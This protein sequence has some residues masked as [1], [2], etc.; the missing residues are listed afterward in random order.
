MGQRL[1]VTH[2]PVCTGQLAAN[3]KR[4]RG[5]SRADTALRN[6]GSSLKKT[7][8]GFDKKQLREAPD[9]TERSAPTYRPP[10]HP[11]LLRRRRWC[12]L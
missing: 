7:M 4:E 6:A 11:D 9:R 3:K 5:N 10:L 8:T 2:A 12:S 1:D